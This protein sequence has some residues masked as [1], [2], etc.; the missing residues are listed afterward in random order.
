ML[1]SVADRN[2][3]GEFCSRRCGPPS[4]GPWIA[5]GL[6]VMVN[7]W[8]LESWPISPSA[9]NKVTRTSA[10]CVATFGT[11]Q[12]KVVPVRSAAILDHDVPPLK[13]TSTSA[14]SGCQPEGTLH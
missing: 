4:P 3:L 2:G 9:S 7:G 12:E 1:V 5:V 13:L 10:A 6:A 14:W 11:T 8:S